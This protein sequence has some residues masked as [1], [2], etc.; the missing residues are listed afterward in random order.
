MYDNF[1]GYSKKSFKQII[2]N[3]IL[4]VPT[5]IQIIIGIFLSFHIV[6]T[7][8]ITTINST[9]YIMIKTFIIILLLFFIDL[10][11][12]TGKMYIIKQ[13][14][15]KN[16]I[17]IKDIFI[18]AKKFFLRIFLGSLVIFGLTFALFLILIVPSAILIAVNLNIIAI[19][20]ISIATIV[21]FIFIS[22]WE[23]II[24]YEDCSI[25]DALNKSV[26][27]AKKNFGIILLI[28]FLK[29]IFTGNNRNL[30]STIY[31]KYN[32]S[33]FKDT[34]ITNLPLLLNNLNVNINILILCILIAFIFELFFDVLIFELYIDRKDSI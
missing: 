33:L 32:K 26:R 19:I 22:M 23:F 5:I 20:I 12:E 10:F 28:E 30:N 18:G 6:A 17:S 4:F 3:P 25:S 11:L 34:K 7:R 1:F 29:G 15:T 8:R 13:S 2:S 9:N 24:I 16:D 31:N 21:F 27:F 14:L